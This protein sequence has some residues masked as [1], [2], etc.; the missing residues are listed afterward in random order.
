MMEKM[1][2]KDRQMT[3][4]VAPGT[5]STDEYI[6]RWARAKGMTRGLCAVTLQSLQDSW[7]AWIDFDRKEHPVKR[8][9]ELRPHT[10]QI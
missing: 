6:R 5:W 3:I 1:K 4:A 8:I 9:V 7:I 2:T 10:F